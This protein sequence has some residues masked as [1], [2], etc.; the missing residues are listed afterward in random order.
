MKTN[1][2]R[3]FS[4]PALI[5]LPIIQ[6]AVVF[7][8]LLLTG[9]N[10]T[11]EVK[12]LTIWHTEVDQSARAALD[13]IMARYESQHPHVK[14]EQVAVPWGELN[15]KLVKAFQAGGLPDVTHLEPFMTYSLYTKG[16]LLH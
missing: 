1:F 16:Q 6:L 5:S 4:I 7:G 13:T 2:R 12:R 3:I 10:S 11:P 9:C 15:N 8:L 14:I